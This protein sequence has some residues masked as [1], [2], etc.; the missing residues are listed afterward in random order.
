MKSKRLANSIMVYAFLV[1]FALFMF[2]PFYW[3]IISSLKSA[4][5]I[6]QK[7]PTIVP[8]NP[9]LENYLIAVKKVPLGRYMLNSLIVAAVSS[10]IILVTSSFAAYALSKLRLPGKRIILSILISLMMVP[11]ELLVVTN[12][13]TIV[14]IHLNNTL[15]ALFLPFISSIFY[16]ILL[17]NFFDRIP[18]SWYYAA[19]VDG[20]SEWMFFWRILIPNSRP[21]LFTISLFSL[22]S[23]WN[24]FM[25]PLLVIKSKQLRT[26][27]FGV[28]SFISEGGERVELMM[29]LSVMTI[30]PMIIVFLLFKR[31]LIAGISFQGSK[32]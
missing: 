7:P 5:E 31:H 12:Y 27:S 11:F 14:R 19:T 3:M 22:I 21:M 15:L 30:L 4:S 23:S 17:K 16:T 6:A 8:V 29:A 9:S 28:Y 26:V 1:L 2:F 32:G 24:S 18:I 13:T 25:W 20:G 10:V